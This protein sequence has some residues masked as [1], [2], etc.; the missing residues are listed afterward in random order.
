MSASAFDFASVGV[1]DMIILHVL[2]ISS[3]ETLGSTCFLP[4]P[5]LGMKIDVDFK[6]A[7]NEAMF[8]TE[9]LYFNDY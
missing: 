7:L 6:S 2:I 1:K 8:A 4:E 5:R 3:N 9:N